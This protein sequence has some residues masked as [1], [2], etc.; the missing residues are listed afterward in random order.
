VASWSGQILI[1]HKSIE[2]ICDAR[3]ILSMSS[4]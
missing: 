3:N 2:L 1:I 4:Q